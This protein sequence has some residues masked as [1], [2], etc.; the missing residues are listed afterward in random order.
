MSLGAKVCTRLCVSLRIS[1]RQLHEQVQIENKGKK[2][3]SWG[4]ILVEL[5]LVYILRNYMK[6]WRGQSPKITGLH[7][8]IMEL[9]N[10]IYGAPLQIMQLYMNYGTASPFT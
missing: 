5:S 6:R 9:H 4:D 8:S 10:S 7:N 3:K 1:G 2:W